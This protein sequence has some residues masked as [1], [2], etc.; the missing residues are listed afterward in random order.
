MVVDL[1]FAGPLDPEHPADLVFGAELVGPVVDAVG[2]LAATLPPLTAAFAAWYD[3]AVPY[4]A[5]RG[6][7]ATAWQTAQ[8]ATVQ[9][10]GQCTQAAH[11][12]AA[13]ALPW[14]AATPARTQHTARWRPASTAVAS[15]QVIAWTQATPLGRQVGAPWQRMASL[16]RIVEAPHQDGADI[17][18]ARRT[19]WA[20][21]L[22]TARPRTVSPWQDGA[23]RTVAL[24]PVIASAQRRRLDPRLP[25]GAARRPPPGL[26]PRPEPPIP[27]Q[28]EP[29]YR[30][31]AAGAVD[32]LFDEV[33]S[34]ATDIYFGCA[35][36]GRPPALIVIPILRTYIVRNETTLTR[37]SD[38]TVIPVYDMSLSL[39]V[40]S[41]AWQWRASA[42]W[43]ARALLVPGPVELLATINGSTIRL[44]CES[45]SRDRAFGKDRLA[46]SGRSRNAELGA[47]TSAI[48]SYAVA[49]T[50]TAAQIMAE[51]LTE[52][53][54]PLP[55]TVDFGLTDW[56][57]PA[58]AWSLQASRIDALQAIAQ[59]AG[60]YIQPHDTDQIVRVLPRYP[61][62]PWDWATLAPDIQ[63]PA[64]V[65]QQEGTQWVS[66]PAYNRVYV[67]GQ[68][69][70][71][72]GQVTRAG[73]AGDVLATMVT[74]SLITHADAARQR[75]LAILADTG[76]QVH[77][78]LRLPVLEETGVIVPGKSVRYTEGAD[79]RI[80]LVRSTS[81]EVRGAQVWQS[82]ILETRP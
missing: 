15:A 8:R 81:V 16:T 5:A 9:A 55:W 53:G 42:P 76:D 45:M 47:P 6:D 64:D 68:G 49:S 17:A 30:P 43:S 67:S 80:G 13:T 57:V 77:Y 70:G 26:S 66:R 19:H 72:L 44:V 33:W 48:Y 50:M 27:P 61:S 79:Q 39:D 51:V 71:V 58:G 54:S 18:T 28:P 29:C 10:R 34:A 1:I 23:R 32:L 4:R 59:A 22:R 41:W 3:N 46:L 74:D 65:V 37:V 38:G 56:L 25:W 73:T 11:I 78:T 21:R 75:G 62:A 40:D 63:L 14:V 2:T 35:G 31:P 7:A 60:G 69:Q 20:D 24:Q 82:I 12:H 52:N 36:A